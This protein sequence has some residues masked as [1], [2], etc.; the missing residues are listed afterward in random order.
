MEASLQGYF[1]VV[2]R[3]IEKGASVNARGKDMSN[4]IMRAAFKGYYGIALLLLEKGADPFARDVKKKSAN[5]YAFEKGNKDI[6]ALFKD[7]KI[8]PIK[9]L[10]KNKTM[11]MN[12]PNGV[13][14]YK[15]TEF[16]SNKEI[17]KGKL[18]IKKIDVKKMNIPVDE[19]EYAEQRTFKLF[20]NFIIGH[21]N[22]GNKN[23]DKICG[24]GM[25]LKRSDYRVFSW[26]WYEQESDNVFKKLQGEGRVRVEFRNRNGFHEIAKIYFIGDQ[27]F[28][29]RK[30][31][32]LTLLTNPNK[33]DWYCTILDG[34]YIV[35]N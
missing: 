29:A 4:A 3:L 18:E 6:L 34:S 22:Y 23:R 31:N 27:I 8:N 28:R 19:G 1:E 16:E 21:S 20:D 32:L 12:A 24:F 26:E 30:E 35:F 17:S 11:R 15:L 33:E 13:M 14:E 9:T 2:K 7:W 5:D 10:N 25:W